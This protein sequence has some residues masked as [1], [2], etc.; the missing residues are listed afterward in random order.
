[1]G[2]C[3][4]TPWKNGFSSFHDTAIASKKSQPSP[5]SLDEEPKFRYNKPINESEWGPSKVRQAKELRKETC[6]LKHQ[7][8]NR[9]KSRPPQKKRRMKPR[10]QK[11]P[12]AN[13]GAQRRP[14]ARRCLRQFTRSLK[15]LIPVPLWPYQ[16][17]CGNVLHNAPMKFITVAE[18]NMAVIGKIGFKP[19]V[20]Y[21][22]SSLRYLR[23]QM[24]S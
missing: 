7:T 13:L 24:E 20:R 3:P 19:S 4:P 18:A 17:N 2:M 8:R 15:S 5:N 21:S 6:P 22:C 10:R 12:A 23:R 1:M 14:S 11:K 9:R 16:K